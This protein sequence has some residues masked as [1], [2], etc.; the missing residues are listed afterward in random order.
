MEERR[1]RMREEDERE[2]ERERERRRREDDDR[3]QRDDDAWRALSARME[4]EHSKR[5][6]RIIAASEQYMASMGMLPPDHRPYVPS[7]VPATSDPT[8][9]SPT[10]PS[11]STTSAR[12]SPTA[13]SR[14][15]SCHSTCTGHT[16][17]MRCWECDQYGHL[18]R[19]CPKN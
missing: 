18:K 12:G 16:P 13:P 19:C 14:S 4:D 1:R 9:P 8:P 11:A 10:P 2:R 15:R 17:R 7:Y 6:E 5:V 3:R